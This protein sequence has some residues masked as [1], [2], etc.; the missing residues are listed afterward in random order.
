PEDQRWILEGEGGDPEEAWQQGI[1]YGV[2]GFF[3]WLESRAYRMHVRVF[4]SRYRSY[5]LCK[6]CRGTRLKP[7]A[8]AFKIAGKTLPD[9]W[10]LSI[11]DLSAFFA[12]LDTVGSDK[13][14]TMLHREIANR[15]G[16]L[17]EVGLGYLDLD[18]PTRT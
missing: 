9:L 5:T 14:T 1:W 11:D 6:A 13:T 7:E 2:R 8:L 15:L 12:G 17:K 16:Y 18:R 10:R 3:D 4:L